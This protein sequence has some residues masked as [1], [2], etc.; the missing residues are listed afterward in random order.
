M[1]FNKGEE[2]IKRVK[3]GGPQELSL[4]ELESV[5]GGVIT[6]AGEEKLR[7][8]IGLAKKLD[9]SMEEVLT[10]LPQY[11]DFFHPMFPETTAQEAIDYIKKNWNSI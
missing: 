10:V 2:W 11:Y 9:M 8:G 3:N 4:E 7:W 6:A 5:S 1:G